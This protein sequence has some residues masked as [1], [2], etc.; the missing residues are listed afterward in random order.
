MDA[1]TRLYRSA[2]Y[3]VTA[4]IGYQLRL[5]DNQLLDLNLRIGNLLNNTDLIYIGA[6][7]RAPNGDISRPDRITVSTTFVYRQPRSATLTAT[8]GF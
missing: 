5:R 3:T 7:P 4:T 2:Y 1:T 6:G 8:I